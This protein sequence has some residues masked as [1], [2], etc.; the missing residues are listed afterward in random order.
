M[1]RFNGRGKPSPRNTFFKKFNQF[2]FERERE[3]G[4]MNGEGADREGDRESQEG[5][6]SEAGLE[7]TNCGFMT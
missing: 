4:R 7:P 2:I 1:G 3:G 5:K 6:E